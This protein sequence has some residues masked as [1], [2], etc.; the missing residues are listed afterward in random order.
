MINWNNYRRWLTNEMQIQGPDADAPH[1]NLICT[2]SRQIKPG[3]WY[4]PLKG[5]K[6]DGH[7]F[8]VD[9]IKKGAQ[10]FFC[11]V[12]KLEKVGLS[13]EAPCCLVK[14]TTQALFEIARGWRLYCSNTLLLAL[15]GSAGKTTTKE[16]LAHMLRSTGET[17]ASAGN[18]NNEIGVAL[19]LLRIN[20]KHRF[21]V[22]EMG[23]RHLGDIEFLVR[24]A[25]PEIACCINV[26]SAHLGEFGSFERLLSTK[27]QIYSRTENFK[28]AVVFEDSPEIVR[29]LNDFPL[30]RFTFGSKEGVDFQLIRNIVTEKSSEITLQVAGRQFSFETPYAHSTTG[31]NT[32]AAVAMAV[33]AGATIEKVIESM[34]TF[35][36]V[37]GRFEQQDYD[38]GLVINDAYNANPESMMAGLSTLK[39]RFG[40]QD[41]W[42]VLGD[43]LELGHDENRLH[44][45]IGAFAIKTTNPVFL[46]TVGARATQIA[47]GAVSAG[48]SPD[49]IKS[50]L[51]V[52]DLINDFS[53]PST[54]RW[55]VYLKASNS[56]QLEKFAKHLSDISK[57]KRGK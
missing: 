31:I 23:A 20:E 41:I 44:F 7:E 27:M 47:K 26:G 48:F 10:G 14:D 8:I 13:S 38:W 57:V 45:D 1:P 36:G 21:A 52:S 56:I 37:S 43:M 53:L 39:S 33:A 5:E 32:A 25:C 49:K 6:F 15:T 29:F 3:D 42:L 34:K 9:A 28:V 55:I 46:T 12:G 30:K 19:T 18:Q 24:M 17:I 51:S 4:L 35:K 16:I 50:F 2:D 11:D 22:I 54:G 40:G